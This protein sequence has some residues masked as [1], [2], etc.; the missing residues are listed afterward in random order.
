MSR[1]TDLGVYSSGTLVTLVS[2]VIDDGRPVAH[3]GAGGV[4]S[5]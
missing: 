4:L 3:D 2:R 5:V 1:G